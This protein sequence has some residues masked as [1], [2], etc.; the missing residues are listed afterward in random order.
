[1]RAAVASAAERE[2]EVDAEAALVA[3]LVV[4]ARVAVG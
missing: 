1:M 4:M 3:E 2:V